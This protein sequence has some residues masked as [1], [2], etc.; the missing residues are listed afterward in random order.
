MK[1]PFPWITTTTHPQTPTNHLC[2]KDTNIVTKFK[3]FPVQ[4]T[5][6]RVFCCEHL[7]FLFCSVR[8]PHIHS[9]SA[10]QPTSSTNLAVKLWTV[11]MSAWGD[12]DCCG[13]AC[14]GSVKL[15]TCLPI[16]EKSAVLA[17]LRGQCS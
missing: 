1:T 9:S 16:S 10:W 12:Q 2:L 5:S 7:K 6:E 11:E 8:S 13:E 15:K 17:Q 4:D 14:E 3:N